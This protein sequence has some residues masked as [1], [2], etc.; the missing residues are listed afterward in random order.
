MS[1]ARETAASS[2]TLSN[3]VRPLTRTFA[4]TQL[5]QQHN[6]FDALMAELEA[7]PANAQELAEASTWVADTFYAHEGA[8]VRT[9]RLR[10]GLSQVQLSVILETSQA[11]VAK[12]ESGRV[13]LQ[14]STL[15]K[16]AQALDVDANTL[17]SLLEAQSNS[18][19]ELTE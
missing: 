6:D 1:T 12:I 11:Q 7:D 3:T 13:D 15:I 10:K 8:T 9:A 17:F 5:A 19:R 18:R 4:V 16:L 14:H 2:A